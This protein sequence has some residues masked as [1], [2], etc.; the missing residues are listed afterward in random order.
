MD[1]G[2]HGDRSTSQSEAFFS[3]EADRVGVPRPEAKFSAQDDG[4]PDVMTA[5]A[6]GRLKSLVERLERLDEDK[7]AV[8]GDIKLVYAE[9]K[10]EGFDPKII[11]KV[12][13]LKKMDA[14]KRAE[15]EA[16]TDLYLNAIG[17]L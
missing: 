3:A 5:A 14:D 10:G 11:R 4:S 13:R 2:F 7:A 8:V 9:A 15:E 17:G 16:L 6:Q 1:I 12:I